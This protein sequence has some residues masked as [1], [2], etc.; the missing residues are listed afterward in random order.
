MASS[1]L[2][3][4]NKDADIEK[5]YGHY[6]AA[7]YLRQLLT[8]S[9]DMPITSSCGRLFDAASALLGVCEISTYE[10][11]AA[12]LLE[13]LVTKTKIMEQGWHIREG[14]LDLLPLFKA[15]LVCDSQQ[16]GANL[17]HGTLIAALTAW[18]EQAANKYQCDT[19]MLSG[20]CLQNKV[21]AC[22]LMKRL[23]EKGL[24]PCMH[25]H[26][27]P[28]DGGLSLGQAWLAGLKVM[29]REKCV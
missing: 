8:Q 25:Q 1:I 6:S 11:Q 15:L 14:V 5:K 24:K 16:A 4:L 22:G 13:S 9:N 18:A 21:L 23:R 26:S 12:M 28:N 10:G 29:E 3:A 19:I 27:P 20:G 7:K 2:A 17:F